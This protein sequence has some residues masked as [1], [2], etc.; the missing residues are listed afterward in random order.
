MSLKVYPYLK[1]SA[2]ELSLGR[3]CQEENIRNYLRAF[4][5]SNPTAGNI[6][7]AREQ[8]R[9]AYKGIPVFKNTVYDEKKK[10][11]PQVSQKQL[12][13]FEEDALRLNLL[14]QKMK[15]QPGVPM[16][17]QQVLS[18]AQEQANV[19][20]ELVNAINKCSEIE[21]ALTDGFRLDQDLNDA[22]EKKAEKCS[23]PSCN[24]TQLDMKVCA[25]CR[26]VAYCSKNHQTTHWKSHHKIA[27]MPSKK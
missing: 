12:D 18:K 22:V 1:K 2:L 4:G 17:M 19:T 16:K 24:V 14:A 25:I 20:S 6:E 26:Q 3:A 15:N 13:K 23:L 10:D 27:C 11:N 7:D 5:N 9:Q 8:M 21:K